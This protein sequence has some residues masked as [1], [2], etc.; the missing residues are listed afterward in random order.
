VWRDL[1]DRGADFVVVDQ[2]GY[3]TTPFYLIP[4]LTRY[5]EVLRPVAVVQ[6]PD[7][8]ILALPKGP[9]KATGNW[10]VAHALSIEGLQK[11]LAGDYTEAIECYVKAEAAF[12]SADN[13]SYEALSLLHNAAAE[14]YEAMGMLDSAENRLNAARG[15]L[16]SQAKLHHDGLAEVLF[17]LGRCLGHQGKLVLAR[18]SYSAAVDHATLGAGRDSPAR[19]RILV[20]LGDIHLAIARPDSATVCYNEARR[21]AA[22]YPDQ[23]HQLVAQVEQRLKALQLAR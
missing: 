20:D 17:N 7:T 22:L 19:A 4:A 5:R 13:A 12:E 1:A 21:I 16:E 11:F 6:R 2:L 14:C 23:A 18:Q 3:G 8:Y 9:D 15:M 10:A